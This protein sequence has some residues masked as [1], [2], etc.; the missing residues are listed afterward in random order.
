MLP[1]FLHFGTAKPRGKMENYEYSLVIQ[2]PF[3]NARV[4]AIFYDLTA[5]KVLR[6]PCKDG[7]KTK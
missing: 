3:T 2:K 6:Q 5:E 4:T 7:E 1:S